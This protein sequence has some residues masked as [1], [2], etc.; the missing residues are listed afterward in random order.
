MRCWIGLWI[1]L[2]AQQSCPVYSGPRHPPHPCIRYVED[3]APM[4]KPRK[5]FSG[6]MD[7]VDR[8]IL[9]DYFPEWDEGDWT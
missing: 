5:A 7:A 8:Q 1:A 2:H 6:P 3:T 4:R 9:R